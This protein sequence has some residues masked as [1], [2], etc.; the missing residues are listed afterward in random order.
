MATYAIGDVH[1]CF[2]TLTR[3]LSRIGY[4]PKEDRLWL[5][6]DLVNRGP[7]S[8]AV[9]RWA[10]ELDPGRSVVVL[11]NHDLHL[12]ARALGLARERRR[13]TLDPILAARDRDDLLAWLRARPLLHREDGHLLVHAGLLPEWTIAE[14]ESLAREVEGEL[15]GERADRLLGSLRDDL[16]GP[17][18]AA[19]SGGARRKLALAAFTRLRTLIPGKGLCTEFSGS[20]EEAPDGCLAWFD[21]PG[22]ESRNTTVLFGH[23]AALG[24]RRRDRVIALDSGCV[25]GRELTAFRL[26]DGKVFQVPAGEE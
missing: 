12:L 13:D 14:A 5:V 17:W 9:L 1:G 8:L 7:R 16:P 26:D 23:W 22:R 3:L 20:P 6:G 10:A 24:Y 21:V 11:G 19:L 15:R 2:A 18:R 25:W 4:S